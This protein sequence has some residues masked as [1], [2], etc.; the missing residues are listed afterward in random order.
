MAFKQVFLE[1]SCLIGGDQRSAQWSKASI[2]TIDWLAIGYDFFDCRRTGFYFF[3][4]FRAKDA[5]YVPIGDA[6]GDGG[7]EMALTIFKYF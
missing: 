1:F 3:S 4:C 2:D 6:E 7:G 5:F